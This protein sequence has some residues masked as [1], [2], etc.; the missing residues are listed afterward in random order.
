[1][2]KESRFVYEDPDDFVI[3]RQSFDSIIMAKHAQGMHDQKTHGRKGGLKLTE[4]LQTMPYELKPTAIQKD[5]DF[6]FDHKSPEIQTMTEEVLLDAYKTAAKED[7]TI[8]INKEA[9]EKV[10]EQG[11]VK[12]AFESRA[13]APEAYMKPYMDQRLRIETEN[14][15]IPA[16]ISDSMRPIYGLTLGDASMYG[17]IRITVKDSVKGR[18]T[19]TKGDSFAGQNPVSMMKVLEGKADA[20]ELVQAT[21]LSELQ[22]LANSVERAVQGA[23]NDPLAN[24]IKPKNLYWETQIHGGLSLSDIKKITIDTRDK[25]SQEVLIPLLKEKGVE[26]EVQEYLSSW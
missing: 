20:N 8:Q 2:G 14:M 13:D 6:Y 12:S 3:I 18:M 16:E 22:D 1:M 5:F 11:R 15:G 26:Y 25:F 21:S 17:T 24:F 19:M 10:L 23:G 7:V 4:P 9:L